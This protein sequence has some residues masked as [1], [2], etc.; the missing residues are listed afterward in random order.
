MKRIAI[1]AGAVL[2]KFHLGFLPLSMFLNMTRGEV[3][4]CGENFVDNLSLNFDG[5]ARDFVVLS[6]GFCP[7]YK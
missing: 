7:H 2:L 5:T 3:F 6:H 4:R 1:S